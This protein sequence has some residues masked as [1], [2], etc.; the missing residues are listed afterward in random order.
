MKPFETPATATACCADLNVIRVDGNRAVCVSPDVECAVGRESAATCEARTRG[1]RQRC[2]RRTDLSER[3]GV[4]VGRVVNVRVDLG[5]RVR[6]DIGKRD[7]IDLTAIATDT[8][9][10]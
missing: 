1:E 8:V 6:A 3:R 4:R 2:W 5:V 10:V 9:H 7:V